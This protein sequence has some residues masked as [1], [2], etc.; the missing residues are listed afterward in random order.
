MIK[1]QEETQRER[2]RLVLVAVHVSQVVQH[3]AVGCQIVTQKAKPE[4]TSQ[5]YL[6]LLNGWPAS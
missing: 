6:R 4:G 3:E 1:L 5:L 2:E